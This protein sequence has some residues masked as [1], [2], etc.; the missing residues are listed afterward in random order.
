MGLCSANTK[1]RCQLKA[2]R[3]YTVRPMIFRVFAENG[4]MIFSFQMLTINRFDDSFVIVQIKQNLFKFSSI[5]NDKKNLMLND[6]I[7]YVLGANL[8]KLD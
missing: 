2:N 6:C 4:Q 7:T 3:I 8:Q 1:H 5:Q